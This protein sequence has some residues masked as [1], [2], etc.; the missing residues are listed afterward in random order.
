MT[1][2]RRM[3]K[4][5]NAGNVFVGVYMTGILPIKKY[6]TQSAMNNFCEY[7]MTDPGDLAPFFGFTHDEVRCQATADLERDRS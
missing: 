7:S 4:E 2:L 3:F 6:E 1:W 5:V